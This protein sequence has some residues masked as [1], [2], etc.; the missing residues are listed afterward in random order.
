MALLQLMRGMGYGVNSSRG[1]YVPHG[2]RSTFRGLV[3]GGLKLP[4]GRSGNGPGP[5]HRKQGGSGPIVRGDLFAKRRKM[6]Q[7]WAGYLER[8][9]YAEEAVEDLTL[10]NRN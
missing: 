4:P 10:S 5:R 7:E 3:R 6:M 2:F 9:K 1:D 8:V